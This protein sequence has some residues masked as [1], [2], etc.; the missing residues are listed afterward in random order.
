[1]V[2]S[3]PGRGRPAKP[4][5]DWLGL[6]TYRRGGRQFFAPFCGPAISADFLERRGASEGGRQKVSGI[7]PAS[8]ATAL[9]TVDVVNGSKRSSRQSAYCRAASWLV[10]SSRTLA[11]SRASVV[12]P[13]SRIFRSRS[14][15]SPSVKIAFGPSPGSIRTSGDL[16]LR[17]PWLRVQARVESRSVCVVSDV[18]FGPELL[19]RAGLHRTSW[20]DAGTIVKED[21]VWLICLFSLV[22]SHLLLTRVH[23]EK[24]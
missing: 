15:A 16:G 14:H 17:S 3:A 22:R 10:V 18:D 12:T 23:N 24:T 20:R 21:L 19:R 9:R 11:T 7:L 1:M 4:W 13:G 8:C 6:G 5:R 2:D